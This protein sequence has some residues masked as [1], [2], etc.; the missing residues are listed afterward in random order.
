MREA[1]LRD[2]MRIHWDVPIEMDDGVALMA[3]VFRPIEEGRYPVILSYG[4]Y[5]KGLL[6]ADGYP[7]QW[8]IMCDNHPD[9][10][11]GS[12]NKYQSW[13]VAD[14][15]RWVPYEYV[16]VRVDSR[17]A[18][19]SAGVIDPYSPRETSD[20]YLCIEWAAAQPWS[21][22]K[23]GLSGISY[24]AINQ[25]QVAALQPPSL[26]ALCIWEGAADWFRDSTRHG[27]IL[28]TFWEPWF[29]HQVHSVQHG[30]GDRGPRS[31]MNGMLVCGDKSLTEEE[32]ERNRVDLAAT[33]AAHPL[34]DD[35]YLER[36][37]DWS[38]ITQPM[39]SA[40]NWGGAGLHLRGNTDGYVRAAST[41]KWLEIHGLEH[42]THYYTDY[43]RELQ[44]RFFDHFLKGEDNGWDRQPRVL[45]N[46]R[47]V[48]GTFEMRQEEGWPIPRTAWTRLYLDLETR[49]LTGEPAAT[50]ASLSYSAVSDGVIF[51]VQVGEELELTGPMAAR[52]FLSSET[53]DADLFLVVR[54]FDPDGREVTFQGALEPH[55]PVAQGWLRASHRKLDPVLST[56]YRPYHTH[57]ELQLLEPGSIYQLDVEIWPTSIVIPAGYTLALN[58][59]GSDFRYS[60]EVAR[61]GWFEMTG[62][63]P[64][65][66]DDPV[67]RPREVFGGTVTL[68]TGGD[69]ESW[70]LVPVIP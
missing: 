31:S 20:I 41:A 47:K 65:K 68:H 51:S 32:L 27:G 38:K 23:V 64:F 49:S 42:W 30:L 53:V 11:A 22:G 66:H 4:P 5:G 46:V 67:D 36:I 24:Y 63:G 58:V 9:V 17:G 69:R 19:R 54:V 45:L 28:S 16:C 59:R 10:Q 55:A 70:L 21:N 8:R 26:A 60:E 13:E 50:H 62:V 57:D 18:G 1:E 7:D 12:S 37:P 14:P 43:G 39:L 56:H 52:L 25:W 2:G 44:R 3:D 6:F 34:I 48:D 33:V 15:E 35:Y 61:F 40:G 29:E